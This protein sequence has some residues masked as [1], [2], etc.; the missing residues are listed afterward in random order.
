MDLSR[1]ISDVRE[2]LWALPYQDRETTRSAFAQQVM[3]IPIEKPTAP[4]EV[5][6]SLVGADAASFD[7]IDPELRPRWAGALNRRSKPELPI[8]GV[9]EW[10]QGMRKYDFRNQ[11]P[12]RRPDW[13]KLLPE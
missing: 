1:L 9:P 12:E 11:D 13:F 7:D 5:P 8:E 2:A 4:D 3:G 6:E 10:A